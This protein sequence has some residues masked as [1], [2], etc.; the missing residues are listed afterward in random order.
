MTSKALKKEFKNDTAWNIL[1]NK[2]NI[3]SKIEQDGFYE[4]SAENIREYREPRLMCKFDH[5]NNLPKVFQDNDVSILPISRTKYVIGQF[6]IFENVKYQKKKPITVSI[7]KH[8]QTIDTNNLYSESAALH[9]AF[10]SGMIHHLLEE[11]YTDNFNHVF[12]TVSGRMGS[13]QFSFEIK[14]PL[15]SFKHIDVNSSQIEIDGGYESRNYFCIIEAKKESVSDFNIRQLFY[16]YR[17]WQNKIKKEVKPIFFTFSN[18]IFSFFI[19]KFT[20]KNVFNSVQLVKQVDFKISHEKIT[21]NDLKEIYQ[22]TK[23]EPEPEVPFPQANTWSR[24]IDLLGLLYD[25]EYLEKDFITE[26]YNFT[27]RQTDYYT[28]IGRYFGIIEKRKGPNK[29]IV[30]SLNKLGRKI[31]SLPYKEKYLALASQILKHEIFNKVFS[32]FF[33]QKHIDK[34]R[35]AE[36]MRECGVYNVD[37]QKSTIERR[38]TTVIPY[39]KWIYSLVD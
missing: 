8:I 20:D 1:F 23:V 2:Y 35:V 21:V 36:I 19:Y 32:E 14:S 29:T 25:E 4:I 3:L 33:M 13:G 5:R 34:K 11:D 18:D 26:N 10:V 38:V 12:P 39:I 37:P 6:D 9:T 22:K 16:P 7:P 15:G 28:N 31:M 17:V 27:E 30:Y 24:V